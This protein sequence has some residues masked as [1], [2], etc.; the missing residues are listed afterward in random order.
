VDNATKRELRQPD[1]FVSFT[2]HGIEWAKNNQQSALVLL[3]VVVLVILGAVGGYSWYQ[4]R[5]TAAQTAQTPLVTPG[6]PLP[7]GMKTFPDAN[8]RAAAANAQFEGVAQK[9]G[10]TQPGKLA[11]YFAGLTF[12]EEGQNASAEDALKKVAG[13]WNGDIAALGKLGLA[14]LYQQTGRDAQAAD[15][16]AELSKGNATTVPP[17][18]AQLQLAE[19]YTS[20]GKA[21]K[22]KEIYAKLKDQDKDAK[23]KEGPAG[24]IAADKLNPK[25]AQEQP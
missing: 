24:S 25:A 7:P 20:E 15:E 6:Q 11:L 1:Q 2:D 12:A 9:Y 18:L 8:A 21:D 19:M 10:M 4:A 22:A 16:Y 17:T 5:T 13:S 23:G 3:G 14:Q